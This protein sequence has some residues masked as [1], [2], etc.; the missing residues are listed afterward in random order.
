MS[1]KAREGTLYRDQPRIACECGEAVNIGR[2]QFH[3]TTKKHLNKVSGLTLSDRAR[4]RYQSGEDCEC[5][6]GTMINRYYIMKHL[7]ESQRHKRGQNPINVKV[8]AEFLAFNKA[9]LKL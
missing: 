2:H 1:Y 8:L 3:L 9:G 6:C 7:R 4:L 5:S